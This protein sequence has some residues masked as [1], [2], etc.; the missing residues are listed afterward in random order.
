MDPKNFLEIFIGDLI[1]YIDR[2]NN[3]QHKISVP[4][5]YHDG[6]GGYQTMINITSKVYLTNQAIIELLK[7]YHLKGVIIDIID[8]KN[9]LEID[10]SFHLSDD[11]LLTDLPIEIAYEIL[12]S[13]DHEDVINACRSN[14]Q[15][16]AICDSDTFWRRKFI[17]D[18]GYDVPNMNMKNI[19]RFNNLLGFG[20]N[21]QGKLGL[22]TRF[23][24]RKPTEIKVDGKLFKAKD[25]ACGQR[26]S[27]IIDLNDVLWGMGNNENGQLGINVDKVRHPTRIM[28]DGNPWK[29]KQI[30]CG[31]NHSLI[32]DM[33]D[34]VWVFGNN[35]KGQLGLGDTI[36]RKYP[37]K[38]NDLKVLQ[39][40][41]NYDTSFIIDD[42]HYLWASGHNEYGQFGIEYPRFFSMFTLITQHPFKKIFT[43]YTYSAAIDLDDNLW[44]M[45]VYI[46][47]RTE[48]STNTAH[49]IMNNDTPIKVKMIGEYKYP[50]FIDDNNNLYTYNLSNGDIRFIKNNVKY[51]FAE[52]ERYFVV[53]FNNNV[54]GVG[55]NDQGQLG[56][57]GKKYIELLTKLSNIKA[58]K[59]ACG[60]NHTLLIM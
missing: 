4:F 19:Y 28:K 39:I 13:L 50:L 3:E 5:L 1:K 17:E 38:I 7:P 41:A 56:L 51:I 31:D 58:K 46:N 43:A 18:Y 15:L 54:W 26:H 53:D 42:N 20:S 30:A 57:Q 33:N 27:L 12:L 47:Y 52:H 55:V 60:E 48:I 29:V 25:I 9:R 22:D 8:Q 6:N 10:L 40:S 2:F 21:S 34:E 49:Q 32:I 16:Q 24:I 11:L 44:I 36:E 37:T 45:S 14:K 35:D 59:I 23:H